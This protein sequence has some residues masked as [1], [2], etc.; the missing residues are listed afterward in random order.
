[1]GSGLEAQKALI[2][3]SIDLIFLPID[4]PNQQDRDFMDQNLEGLHYAPLNVSGQLERVNKI[5]SFLASHPKLL[6]VIDVSVEIA[7][8]S[9]LCGVPTIVIRQHGLRDDLPHQ[10]C[11]RNAAGL[12]AP[13]DLQMSGPGPEWVNEKTFY[14]GGF[15]RFA[16]SADTSDV[17]KKQVA[18][19]IGRGGTS[20]NG[21]FL[22][23]LSS[24]CPQWTFHVVGDSQ[25]LSH[26]HNLQFHGELSDPQ[27]ILTEC[28]IVIGNA[29]HN[30]VME[31]AS[32]NKRFIAIAEERPFEEQEEKARIIQKLALA[33]HVS[34]SEIFDLDWKVILENLVTTH[35]NW[36]GFISSDAAERAADYLR[37]THRT[38]FQHH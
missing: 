37:Q 4:T 31:C 6:F 2:P 14:T 32:L 36:S 30:T 38:L 1:M 13:F 27:A 17:S 22:D 21:Q 7:M 12:L 19:L 16:P 3:N 34:A 25:H 35:P 5:T 29:G 23:Y 15:S 9:R 10:I 8:L 28:S 33:V 20:I 24:Q 11:Y 18:V 26:I